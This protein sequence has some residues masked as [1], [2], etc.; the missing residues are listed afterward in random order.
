[1]VAATEQR[2]LPS[3]RTVLW[4]KKKLYSSQG[5]DELDIHIKHWRN[6]QGTLWEYIY[7]LQVVSFLVFHAK[8]HPRNSDTIF[9]TSMCTPRHHWHENDATLIYIL[10]KF[11]VNWTDS[12]RV[13]A[14]LCPPVFWSDHYQ[15]IQHLRPWPH[16][17]LHNNW[18]LSLPR[19]QPMPLLVCWLLE[20]HSS[21]CP[22]MTGTWKMPTTP[23]PYFSV[24]WRTGS[25][26]AA[27]HLIART[28]SDT[29]LQ[30]WE[31]NP[32][33]CRC[34]GCLPA[35]KR[36]REQPRQSFCL[37]RPNTP[38]NDTWHQH[39]CAPWRTQRCCGQARR[40]PP[41]SHHMHQDTDGPLWDD[42]WWAPWA[43]AVLLY[44]P[45]L[46]SWGKA[47]WETYGKT[48]QDTF[49][50]ASWHQSEPLCHSACLRTSLPQLQ[51]CGCNLPWQASSS[52]HQSQ[53]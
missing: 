17:W 1:M 11:E 42:Q 7:T 34:N 3:A 10:P 46:L 21:A 43:Q 32:W 12:S 29:S 18:S 4:Y 39:P 19:P 33:R 27:S 47:P 50:Q 14:I 20:L 15:T 13:T 28:T 41:R 9:S 40:G 2:N 8:M 37:P 6:T 49:L 5:R 44:H 30:P 35:A 52:Q 23:S 31:S 48:I 16:N 51:T 25:S 45:W 53:W 24:P 36:N 26:L 38:G 22:S